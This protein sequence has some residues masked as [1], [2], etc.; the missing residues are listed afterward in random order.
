MTRCTV[1]PNTISP[2]AK[3]LKP[4]KSLLVK[5]LEPMSTSQIL[6][7]VHEMNKRVDFLYTHE[8]GRQLNKEK[9]QAS[10]KTQLARDPA[11]LEELLEAFRQ[12]ERNNKIKE[13]IK[14]RDMLAILLLYATKE[15]I[16]LILSATVQ[17]VNCL[18]NK[19]PFTLKNKKGVNKEYQ[20]GDKAFLIAL[21]QKERFLAFCETK[22]QDDFIF[23]AEFSTKPLARA[24]F[25]FKINAH[26]ELVSKNFNKNFTSQS[27]RL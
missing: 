12:I 9:R 5:I 17:T 19:I 11:G 24:W 4:V 14:A 22:A 7:T 20:V 2:W 10:I 15:K 21:Q 23:T 3:K 27:F 26:L 8:I 25:D 18:L 16:S 1:S 13:Y 6:H